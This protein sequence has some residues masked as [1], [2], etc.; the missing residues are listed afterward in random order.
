[1]ARKIVKEPLK[2]GLLVRKKNGD[3]DGWLVGA[4]GVLLFPSGEEA[5]KTLKKM[6]KDTHYTWSLP[7]VVAPY[8][9]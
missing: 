9:E 1:M 3:P 5:E 2:F 7:V 4:N 6:K 8:H